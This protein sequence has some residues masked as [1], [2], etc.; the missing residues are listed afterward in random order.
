VP[1][2]HRT[3]PLTLEELRAL[4]PTT[5]FYAALVVELPYSEVCMHLGVAGQRWRVMPLA[6]GMA[7]LITPTGDLYSMPCTR[8][9]LGVPH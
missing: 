9:E 8:G 6:N 3:A 1:A 5:R 4:S 2:P 7:Q